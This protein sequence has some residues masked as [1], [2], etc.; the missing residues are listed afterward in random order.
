MSEIDLDDLSYADLKA[1]EKKVA[2]TIKGFKARK[3]KEAR[4]AVA[5][6]AKEMG[7]SLEELLG[8]ATAKDAKKAQAVAKYQHPENPALTWSGR[9][10]QP[11]WFKEA[12]AAGTSPD[13]LDISA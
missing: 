1:L 11:V 4:A 13:D 7:Y 6:K 3:L 12:I 9:G 2:K 5:A 10:R 8:E